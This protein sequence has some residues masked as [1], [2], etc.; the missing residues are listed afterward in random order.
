[1]PTRPADTQ[2]PGGQESSTDTG[3]WLIEKCENVELTQM[4]YSFLMFKK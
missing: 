3:E 1:M 4:F 2:G